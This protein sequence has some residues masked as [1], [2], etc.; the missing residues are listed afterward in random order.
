[1]PTGLMGAAK[2]DTGTSLD[3]WSK[4]CAVTEG[5]CELALVARCCWRSCVC[6]TAAT[7]CDFLNLVIYIYLCMYI[8]ILFCCTE[9]G[10]FDVR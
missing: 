6:R 9:F 5:G 8:Y 2:G 1:V 7:I 4:F 10:N 3:P